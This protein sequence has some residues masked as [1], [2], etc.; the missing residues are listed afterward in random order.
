[1]AIVTVS[2]SQKAA[3]YQ[4]KKKAYGNVFPCLLQYWLCKQDLFLR[5]NSYHWPSAEA[6]DPEEHLMT[7][8][9]HSTHQSPWSYNLKTPQTPWHQL[10]SQ[11][12][13]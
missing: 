10:L 12:F 13:S 7:G 8:C 4:Q 2:Q 11:Q 1:M 9:Q 3:F 6:A 5:H